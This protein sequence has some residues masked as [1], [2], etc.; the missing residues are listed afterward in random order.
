M[1]G[2]TFAGERV[3]NGTAHQFWIDPKHTVLKNQEWTEPIQHVPFVYWSESTF[4]NV[5]GLIDKH[6]LRRILTRVKYVKENL[7]AAVYYLCK[8]FTNEI[9]LLIHK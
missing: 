4:L 1:N 2:S 7:A 8:Y 5:I 9:Q 6:K 3:K